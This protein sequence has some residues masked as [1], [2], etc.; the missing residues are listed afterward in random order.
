MHGFEFECADPTLLE[1]C[2]RFM[3]HPSDLLARLSWAERHAFMFW[4]PLPYAY[5]GQ[6]AN[7]R[8]PLNL[9]AQCLQS[10]EPLLHYISEVPGLHEACYMWWD[11]CGWIGSTQSLEPLTE[12]IVWPMLRRLVEA[13]CR[14]LRESA[15]HGVGEFWTPQRDSYIRAIMS[16]AVLPLHEGQVDTKLEDYLERALRGDVL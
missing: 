10:M 2:T 14:S 11:L 16:G 9:R 15:I 13:P 12:Q 1:L 4:F 5:L 8:L 6:L 7:D 3:T